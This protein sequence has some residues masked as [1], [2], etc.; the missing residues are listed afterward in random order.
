MAECSALQGDISRHAQAQE[1]LR[2]GQMAVE[3]RLENLLAM[4]GTLA[5]SMSVL[6][7]VRLSDHSPIHE[8]C[9]PSA[10]DAAAFQHDMRELQEL[11]MRKD[12]LF[13][14][15][16]DVVMSE[17]QVLK[18]DLVSVIEAQKEY[19][20]VLNAQIS[21]LSQAL[22]TEHRHSQE[23][24]EA[25]QSCITEERFDS[26]VA[27]K[28]RNIPSQEAHGE[29]LSG[30]I[31]F[32]S[33]EA[34]REAVDSAV[35]DNI[36]GIGLSELIRDTTSADIERELRRIREAEETRLAQQREH[37]EMQL[38]VR[39]ASSSCDK[40]ISLDEAKNII[41]REVSEECSSLSNR[42][43]GESD[44]S[45][46]VAEPDHAQR[47]AG[48]T[49]VPEFTSATYAR[50]RDRGSASDVVASVWDSMSD[51]F[52]LENGIGRPEDALSH[53]VSLGQCWA[54][55][56]MRHFQYLCPTSFFDID[57]MILFAGNSRRAYDSTCPS[58]SCNIGH[59]GSRFKVIT[60]VIRI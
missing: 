56:V 17:V 34:L 28:L 32:A 48:A 50:P 31:C 16:Y 42:D 36:D 15:E 54:M 49:V 58:S 4:A 27:D 6:S 45:L 12:E 26:I 10:P 47:G 60:A 1:A 18:V 23:L 13:R 20:G 46:T 8:H 24:S 39:A 59:S 30:T 22:E 19:I 11:L 51:Y 7:D 3:A 5:K 40:C 57:N 9:P 29:D 44:A 52:G 21:D 2:E 35:R 14:E 55:N 33:P 41:R 53:R 43:Q 25:I 37:D 38:E